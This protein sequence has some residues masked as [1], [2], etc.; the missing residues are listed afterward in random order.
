MQVYLNLLSHLSNDQKRLGLLLQG[1][2][3]ASWTFGLVMSRN[4]YIAFSVFAGVNMLGEG[5]VYK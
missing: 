3:G 4:T 2:P 5:R 1:V